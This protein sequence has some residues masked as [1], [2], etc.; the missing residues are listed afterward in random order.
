MPDDKS[1]NRP[2]KKHKIILIGNDEKLFIKV[3]EI[4]TTGHMTQGCETTCILSSKYLDYLGQ[5]KITPPSFVICFT[6]S[7]NNYKNIFVKIKEVFPET[8]RMLIV[9]STERDKIIDSLNKEEIHFCLASPFKDA[10][11]LEQIKFGLNELEHGNTWEYTSRIV[12]A[13]KV[14]MYKIAKNFK[15]KDERYIKIVNQ[16]EQEYQSLKSNL[17]E[18]QGNS[19]KDPS[20][21]EYIAS[22]YISIDADSFMDE[23]E[24]LAGSI[25]RVFESIAFKN[26]IDFSEDKY[27]DILESLEKSQPRNAENSGIINNL[28]CHALDINALDLKSDA[29]E[30]PAPV[31]IENIKQNTGAKQPDETATEIDSE[32][33]MELLD[34]VLK[35]EIAENRLN[36]QIQ[37]KDKNFDL[38]SP[39]NIFEY[40]RA[41][42]V[43]YG[44]V[45]EQ[46][47]LTWLEN[48]GAVQQLI[49]AKGTPPELPVDGSVT[50]NFDTDFIHAGKV[51][52]DGSMDFRERGDIPFVEGN[53]LLAE[54]IP[55]KIGK[56]GVD[57]SGAQ[58]AVAEP[59]DPVFVAG[60]NTFESEGGL[61]IFSETGGQPH[62]D[63]M[64]NVSVAP[65][66]NIDSNVDFETG[67]ISFKGN[68]VVNG[69][70]K[71][72]FKVEGTNLTAKQIEGAQIYL[73]GA[74]NVSTGIIDSDIKAQGNVQA[75]Y[76]N[77][78]IIETFGDLIITTE[79]LD[80]KIDLSGKFNSGK[81]RIIGSKIVAKGGIEVGQ[82]GT[83]S[84]KPVKLR[85]GVDDYITN[86]VRE[87]DK[88]L[89]KVK[90]EMDVIKK[91]ADD[92]GRQEK[93]C[94]KSVSE[95][96]YIQDR[97]QIEIREYNEKLSD[98]KESGNSAAMQT[99]SNEI[100][101]LEEKS[102][103]AE[104]ATEKALDNQDILAEKIKIQGKEVA[105]LE[106]KNVG[107]VNEK[108]ALNKYS[109][110]GNIYAKVVVNNKVV[111]GTRVESLNSSLTIRDDSTKCVIEEIPMGANSSAGYYEMRLID[112]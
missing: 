37:I 79:V 70:V 107:F 77:N 91:G 59:F 101:K 57:I 21:Q 14:K 64:G 15:D 24:K 12:D 33:L 104:K 10:D 76:I 73:T 111:A 103:E 65:V 18:T 8:R 112:L 9:E 80:S 47:L 50:Y 88:K 106:E 45:S 93:K 92:L 105:R 60:D 2:D 98:L 97:T 13:Q 38:L 62:L 82:I 100:K 74:L 41:I 31:G 66:L 34:N 48:Q 87:I 89:I 16:K 72:G 56:P 28:I 49:V 110:K 102:E 17:G 44:I 27:S 63:V 40:L 4:L 78:S 36:V 54:K 55:A 30:E 69:T 53:I 99:I 25:A 23:F 75:K 83:Q 19:V 61:K 58:I 46:T 85:V 32:E 5:D 6:D 35:V 22:K 81:A 20:L 11:F 43:S 39:E 7:D 96:A 67:N 84:S 3:K 68:I 109:E 94:F 86:L 71:E 90:E 26:S 108:K 29:E 95:S 1:K 42:G 52:S 51:K